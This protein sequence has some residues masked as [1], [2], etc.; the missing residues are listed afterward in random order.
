M[1]QRIIVAMLDGFGWDYWEQSAMPN[2]RRMAESGRIVRGSAVFPT[3]T[4]VNN[5]SIACG[6]WPETH[7][8]ATNCYYDQA[9]NSAK[10][11]EDASFLLCQTLFTRAAAQGIKSALLTCKAK[12]LGILEKDVELGLAAENLSGN[13]LQRY[14]SP[15]SMYSAEINYWLWEAALDILTNRPD[16][17]FLYVH[18][19][20]FPMHRWHPTDKESLT[21]LRRVDEYLGAAMR[22]APDAALL[23][24]ADHGMNSKTTC[25]D[26]AKICAKRGRP[27]KYAVSPVADRLLEHHGGHGGVSYLYLEQA[28][29]AEDVLNILRSLDGVED[30]LDRK[31]AAQRFRLPADR[32]GDLVVLADRDCVFGSLEEERIILP[33]G[34]RNHGSLHE[35][36]IPIISYNLDDKHKPARQLKYNFELTSGL[37]GQ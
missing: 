17:G 36:D 16:I 5:V 2:L 11:L 28:G 27:L 1:R 34:Y 21:H 32:L 29:E 15:P 37:F 13:L 22:K 4:N 20:D 6:C 24:T 14:S 26:L 3:L 8:V 30:V 7:G 18:T 23:A 19:T 33:A 10:F 25:L 35:S 12:T 31:T 9:S